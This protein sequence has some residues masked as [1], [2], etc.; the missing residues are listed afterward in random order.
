MLLPRAG[1]DNERVTRSVRALLTARVSGDFPLDPS[2]LRALEQ[3]FVFAA[4]WAFGSALSVLDGEVCVCVVGLYLRQL[5]LLPTCNAPLCCAAD[6]SRL[7]TSATANV[8]VDTSS[9]TLFALQDM[10][11]Q[12]SDYWRSCSHAVRLP[13]RDT[14]FDYCLQTDTDKFEPWK[15]SPYFYSIEYVSTTPMSQVTVPTPETCSLMFW[16][17]VSL[18]SLGQ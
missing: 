17:E 9:H 7:H 16:M 1:A 4:I 12:F 14:V 10:R 11:K 3:L 2:E 15:N 8:V 6:V 5:L 13:S 18:V